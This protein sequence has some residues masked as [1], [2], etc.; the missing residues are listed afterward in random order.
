MWILGTNLIFVFPCKFWSSFRVSSYFDYRDTT[1]SQLLDF[2]IHNLHWFFYK[3]EF[4]I[5]PK[6]F[7]KMMRDSSDRHFFRLETWKV[8]WI[9][10]S[11]SGSLSV[12]ATGPTLLRI[13]N[14]LMYRGLSFPR[15]PNQM[16]PFRACKRCRIC[17]IF[18]VVS[19]IISSLVSWTSPTSAQQTGKFYQ[20]DDMPYSCLIEYPKH[21]ALIA[22]IWM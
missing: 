17:T 9:L 22:R 18:L 4:V 1:L 21:S 10:L 7:H 2:S 3:V 15:F 6:L 11:S 19:W 14:G 5:E 12:Y 13:L 8:L 16:T 20:W